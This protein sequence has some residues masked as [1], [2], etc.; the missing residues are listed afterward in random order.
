[1][2][3]HFRNPTRA[4]FD[5]FVPGGKVRCV[6]FLW[7]RGAIGIIPLW[8]KSFERIRKT[9]HFRLVVSLVFGVAENFAESHT[10]IEF[11][12]GRN[13]RL[14]SVDKYGRFDPKR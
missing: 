12:Y 8:E 11:F 1:M 13:K 7:V 9:V 10:F 2:S 6:G 5:F 3:V 14:T 4:K